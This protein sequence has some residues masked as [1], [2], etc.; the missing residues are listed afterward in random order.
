MLENLSLEEKVEQV[1]VQVESGR[2]A[3]QGR[4]RKA[5]AGSERGW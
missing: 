3:F 2:E 5:G 4:L 1:L